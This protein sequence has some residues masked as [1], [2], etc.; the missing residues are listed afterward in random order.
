MA[1][2]VTAWESKGTKAGNP[3]AIVPMRATRR[4]YVD[5][6][7]SFKSSLACLCPFLASAVELA[8]GSNCL[9]ALPRLPVCTAFAK[10]EKDTGGVLLARPKLL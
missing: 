7:V 1:R 2:Q 9:M 5:D 6:S 8:V 10:S 3:A 4:P